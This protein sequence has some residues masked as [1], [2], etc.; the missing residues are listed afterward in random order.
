MADRDALKILLE[1]IKN[2]PHNEKNKSQINFRP[3]EQWEP[4]LE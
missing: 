1:R 4:L 3:Q 2:T